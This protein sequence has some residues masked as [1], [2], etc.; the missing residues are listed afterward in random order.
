M[1]L[2]YIIFSKRCTSN[3]N[4]SHSILWK[5]VVVIEEQKS[6]RDAEGEQESNIFPLR[7]QRINAL[8]QYNGK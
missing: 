8:Y 5:Q 1:R 2:D 7:E 6:V 3:N 4:I